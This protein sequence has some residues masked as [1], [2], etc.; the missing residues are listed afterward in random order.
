MLSKAG[1]KAAIDAYFNAANR[2]GIAIL[3]KPTV[4]ADW[5]RGTL[6]EKV[7]TMITAIGSLHSRS[8][9]PAAHA[10]VQLVQDEVL[11]HVGKQTIAQHTVLVLL[12][13]F[14]FD[15]GDYAEAWNL[16]A[17]AARLIFTMRLNHEQKGTDA[18][19]REMIRRSVWTVYHRR[20]E[21]LEEFPPGLLVFIGRWFSG[22]V[23]FMVSAQNPEDMVSRLVDQVEDVQKA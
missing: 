18:V 14:R 17:L 8:L 1:V 19:R 15:I 6:D 20:S 12:L 13:R 11:S 10:K 4:L 9:L 21:T 2:S 23:K 22:T 5:S 3:H 16:L 7:L